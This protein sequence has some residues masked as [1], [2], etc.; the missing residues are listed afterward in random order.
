MLVGF[1]EVDAWGVLIS[2]SIRI[3]M[4]TSMSVRAS[5]IH[6]RTNISSCIR[7][8]IQEFKIVIVVLEFEL[9]FV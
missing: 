9:A 6:I 4:N 3:R 5:S 8:R 7:S 2:I 1:S